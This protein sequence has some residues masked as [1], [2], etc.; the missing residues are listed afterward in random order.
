MTNTKRTRMVTAKFDSG[1]GNTLRIKFL[2][3][4][5]FEVEK[6]EI[7]ELDEDSEN[8]G[9]NKKLGMIY[10]KEYRIKV[11][12]YRNNKLPKDNKTVKWSYSYISSEGVATI[13]NIKQTGGI[14]TFK[15]NNLDLCGNTITFHA[16]IESKK[17]EATL[18]VEII[19]F[20]KIIFVNGHWNKIAHKI[21]MS[22]GKPGKGYW[23]FFT[24]NFKSYENS[25]KSYFGINKATVMFVDGSSSLGIDQSGGDRKGEGCK[26]A[27]D[28]FDDFVYSLGN[29][30]VY[31]ISHSEGGAFAAGIAKGLIEKGIKIKESIMLS[32][33]EGDEFS[34]EENY[35][36]YQLTAGYLYEKNIPNKKYFSVDP[37][38][39]DNKVKGVTKYGVYIE[40]AKF[41]TVHGATIDSQSFSYIDKLKKVK[42]QNGLNSKGKAIYKSIPEDNIWYRIDDKII[43][44]ER[45]DYYP[46][47]DNNIIIQKYRPR[48]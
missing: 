40:D 2:K 25:A 26:Y 3:V 5:S 17:N 47:I 13:G 12:K 16:Y 19:T 6:I 10:G 24:G 18:E 41:S 48:E 14:I 36:C 46:Y 20:P 32:T 15:I 45:I 31:L 44:N 42:T 29:D 1:R 43:H 35:I 23:D 39:G 34:I 30:S 28:N 9:G 4:E 38:V 8:G 7:L 27:K 22:P 37:V 11:T 21:G 33:D